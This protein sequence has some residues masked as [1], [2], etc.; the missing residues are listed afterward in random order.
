MRRAA[1][2]AILILAACGGDSETTTTTSPAPVLTTLGDAPV[3]P[4]TTTTAP[5]TTTTSTT[6]TTTTLAPNAAAEFGLTQVVFGESAFV[7]ITNWGN[8]TGNLLGHWLC[9]F[10]SYQSLP[11]IELAPGEQVLVGLST[12]PPPQ[13]S[14]MAITVDLGSA[15]GILD[16]NSGEVVLYD[17]SSFED[18]ESIVAYVE[19]GE[20]GHHRAILAIQA[21]VWS[22]GAVEVFDEAPSISSGVFPATLNTDWSADIGG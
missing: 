22:E 7:I 6:T 16:P 1:L 20:T 2:I 17:S 18:P 15:I 13:L 8:N 14:G 11:D 10:P 21:G 12:T 3:P 19:W 5:P 9:Q 4:T